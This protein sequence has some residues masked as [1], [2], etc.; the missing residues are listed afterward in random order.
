MKIKLIFASLAASLSL[1][2]S[3]AALAGPT[4][5][6][7]PWVPCPNQSEICTEQLGQ[8]LDTTND[9]F[10]C[11]TKSGHLGYALQSSTTGTVKCW[12]S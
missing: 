1:I 9:G 11:L 5:G 10:D 4:A 8:D 3:G 7:G 12:P 2:A 6:H